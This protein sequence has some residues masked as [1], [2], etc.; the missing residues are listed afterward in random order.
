MTTPITAQERSAIMAGV[1]DFHDGVNSMNNIYS[2]ATVAG[3][4]LS[5]QAMRSTAGATLSK[6]ITQWTDDFNN[7]KALLQAMADQLLST[8]NQTVSA[9]QANA[10]VAA[11]LAYTPPSI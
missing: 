4:T 6:V 11:A 2:G 9:D 10:E 1:N 3:S 5:G 8:T 7:I